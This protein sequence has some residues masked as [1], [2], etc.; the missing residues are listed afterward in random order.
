MGCSGFNTTHRRVNRGVCRAVCAGLGSVIG[1]H[2]IH[3][4]MPELYRHDGV[5]L[6]NQG[7]ELFLHKFRGG[8][9]R[10]LIVWVG[11]GL[12][13]SSPFAVVGSCWIGGS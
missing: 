5:H 10:L 6:S 1:H 9:A 4:D 12:S 11:K 7:L 13:H 8:C 3:L 2:G